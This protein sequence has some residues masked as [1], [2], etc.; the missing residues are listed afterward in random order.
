MKVKKGF[1]LRD[2]CGEKVIIA[3][4]I[5]NLDFNRLISLN[6]TAAYLWQKAQEAP[7]FTEAELAQKLVSDYDVTPETAEADVAELVGTWRKQG[8]IED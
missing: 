6:E 7:S 3:T 4:G 5:E 8:L 2:V 1:E